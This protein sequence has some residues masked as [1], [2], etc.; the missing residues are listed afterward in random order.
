M[1][2]D[3]KLNYS[4][5]SFAKWLVERR[6]EIHEQLRPFLHLIQE[7]RELEAI[8]ASLSSPSLFEGS[9]SIPAAIISDIPTVADYDKNAMWINKVLFVIREKGEAMTSSDI[10]KRIMEIEPYLDKKRTYNSVTATISMK[11]K[12][13]EPLISKETNTRNEKLYEERI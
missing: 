12:E 2:V 9:G 3:I 4:S 11:S 10:V 1:S 13:G 7:D 5:G 8:Q 6:K